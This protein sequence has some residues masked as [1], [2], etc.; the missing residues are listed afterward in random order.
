VRKSKKYLSGL[1]SGLIIGAI[2]VQLAHIGAN[3]E[4]SLPSSSSSPSP[5]VS[6][7]SFSFAELAQEA[8]KLNAV[9]LTT[10]DYNKLLAAK[11]QISP[12]PVGGEA[13]A[14]PESAK[15]IYIYIYSGMTSD[16]IE[17]YLYLAGIITDR[18]AFREHIRSG[19]LSDSLKADLY[20]FTP[21]MK[22]EDVIARL[23]GK[24][25]S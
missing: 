20:A 25:T 4:V 14:K 1:G 6:A 19:K 23:T 2:L 9:L 22:L 17:E 11:P 12:S 5:S 3:A 18:V 10:A 16:S 21:G 7:M 13:A 24:P 15:S 8:K